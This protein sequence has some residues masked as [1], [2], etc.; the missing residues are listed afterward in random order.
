VV[1]KT[2][3]LRNCC[4]QKT[5]GPAAIT[6]KASKVK[7]ICQIEDGKFSDYRWVDG[8]WNFAEF[9][10]GKGSTD[11]DAV[12]PP[13]PPLGAYF[14]GDIWGLLEFSLQAYYWTI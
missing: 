4:L 7:H 6:K 9:S 5:E 14:A 12:R 3:Y 8:T 1:V 2:V 11:W 10:D 13:P